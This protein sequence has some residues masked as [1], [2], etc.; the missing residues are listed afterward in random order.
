MSVLKNQDTVFYFNTSNPYR[1]QFLK[2]NRA[3]LSAVTDEV[4]GKPDG[5]FFIT[6]MG[7][8]SGRSPG[9]LIETDANLNIIHEWPDDA[10]GPG[11]IF[12]QQF[13]PHGITVDWQRRRVLTSDFIEPASILKPS[14][15]VKFAS[16]LRLWDLDSKTI[17]NTIT[18]PDVGFSLL[19]H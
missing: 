1:P 12:E 11:D 7:S 8:A 14:T 9:R 17:L 4:V 16:T 5:G 13:S 6:N 19:L 15:G 3:F 2:S 18:I 10:N